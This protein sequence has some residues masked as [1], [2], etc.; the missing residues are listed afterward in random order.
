[1]NFHMNGIEKTMAE[2]HGMLKTT[3]DSIKKNHNHLMIVQ[4]EK[5]KRKRWTPR[6]DKGKEK[7][8]DEPS[9]SKPKTKW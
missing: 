2:L 5:I 4:K 6:K 3:K 7:V 8:S 9:S 1:M